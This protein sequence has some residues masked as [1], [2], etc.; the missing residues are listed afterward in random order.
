MKF[1][2]RIS[3]F[4]ILAAVVFL[5]APTQSATAQWAIGA[6]YEMKADVPSGEP[7]TGFG[8]R[9]DKV[10]GLP[11]PL[12]DLRIRGH[13]SYF[14]DENT[15][16]YDASGIT[17]GSYS[18]EIT[19]Y[20]YGAQLIGQLNFLV[21]PYAG[22]GIGSEQYQTALP[23]D[24]P[25]EFELDDSS[26]Y[27]TGTAGIS[28]NV[29]PVLKPFVEYRFKNAFS[30]SELTEYDSEDFKGLAGQQSRIIFGVLLQF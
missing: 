24:A 8:A 3:V 27:W 23:S 30:P 2:K 20:D 13:F 10:L 21:S 1:L 11:L 25:S 4:S 6:S 15:L 14:S 28:T 19:N 12:L 26:F 29:I 16:E 9:I 7:S 22:I 18:T 5:M 17:G